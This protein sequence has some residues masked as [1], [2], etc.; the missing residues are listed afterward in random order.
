MSLC[1]A[2]QH[3]S[4]RLE[5][6]RVLLPTGL[7]DVTVARADWPLDMLCGF[8]ARN[9]PKRGFLVVSKVLGRHIGARPDLMRRSAHDLA[10][11]LPHDLPGPVLVV[12][13]AE[14]AICLGQLVHEEL[15]AL[16]GRTDLLFIHSTRQQLDHPML[17]RFEEPHSHASAHLIYRPVDGWEPPH[18]LVLVDDELS[19]GTTI[20]NLATS[21]VAACPSIERVAV[22][23][24]TDWSDG[25]WRATMPRPACSVALLEGRLAWRPS[26]G[27]AAVFEAAPA[28]LGRLST[29][30]NTGRLGLRKPLTIDIPPPPGPV[31][32]R[33]IGTGECS[34]PA[35]RIAESWEQA[36]RDVVVQA[37]SRSPA[38]IGGAIGSALRFA[39]NYGTGVPNFLYNADD[40][41]ENWIV[42]EP[43]TEPVDPAL[44]EALGAR[45]VHWA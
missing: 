38:R 20:T 13:L 12:G 42:A 19:T 4:G 25:L 41:R 35:F 23:T 40:A 6:R 32:L 45:V 10:A 28:A 37:T 17:C 30:R 15:C 22:A 34:F 9:N 8:A 5:P 11:K 27:P 1:K 18:S 16:S 43:G 21:L 3:P 26:T 36:G 39:D 24:L 33:V 31:P 2:L 44:I 14:T 29:H 7:L